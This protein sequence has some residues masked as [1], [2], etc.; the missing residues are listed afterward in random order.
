[1]CKQLVLASQSPRRQSLLAQLGYQFDII[2]SDIDEA[3][4]ENELAEDY[5]QR[6]AKEKALHVFTSLQNKQKHHALVLGSDTCVVIEKQILGKPKN[7]ADCINM[8]LLLS[9]KQ[10]QVLTSI[11][12]AYQYSVKNK[13]MTKV[14]VE[15][16]TTH[17]LF[18]ALTLD[19]IK[20]YWQSEEPKDKAGSY[21]IQGLGGQFVKSINGSYSAVVG[22]PLYET[23]ELLAQCGLATRFQTNS[24]QG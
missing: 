15:L 5:V 3:V 13:L 7:E 19:E 2:A 22:L 1:M 24:F 12:V 8:L 10:H 9:N 11:A 17:V 4:H 23:V 6:L 20:R 14:V 18:K 16:I 21:A